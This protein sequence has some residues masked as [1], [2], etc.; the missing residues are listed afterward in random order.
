LTPVVEKKVLGWW[1]FKRVRVLEF[2]E[3]AQGPYTVALLADIGAAIFKVARPDRG[4]L[5]CLEDSF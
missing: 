4:D 3:G 2:S 1:T 5:I